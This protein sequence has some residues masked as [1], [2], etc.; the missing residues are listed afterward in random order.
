MPT[1]LTIGVPGGPPVGFDDMPLTG[2][3]IA[4]VLLVG[5]VLIL[6]LLRARDDDGTHAERVA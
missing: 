3:L 4:L 2:A 5:S 6:W 1:S